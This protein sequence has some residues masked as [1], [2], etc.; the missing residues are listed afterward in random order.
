MNVPHRSIMSAY[1]RT[2][3]QLEEF[4]SVVPPERRRLR[5]W[6]PVLASILLE[7]GT[8]LHSLWK[9]QISAGNL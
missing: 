3:R 7:V 1:E 9:L 4:L 2:E 8:Q 5:V 6:S